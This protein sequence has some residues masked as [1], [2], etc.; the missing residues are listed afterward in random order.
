MN[1]EYSSV[2]Q[3]EGKVVILSDTMAATGCHL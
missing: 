3:I 2:P 1:I